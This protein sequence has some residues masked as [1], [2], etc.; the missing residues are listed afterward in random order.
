MFLVGS[1]LLSSTIGVLGD[2]KIKKDRRRMV[3]DA[4]IVVLGTATFNPIAVGVG[5][6][7][8]GTD[9]TKLAIHKRQDRKAQE[10]SVNAQPTQVETLVAVPQRPGYYY[11][12]SNPN[13]LYFDQSQ[14]ADPMPAKLEA[15]AVASPS[16]ITVKIANAAKDGRM[17]TC[18]VE[19]TT[20][21]VPPGYTQTLTAVPNAVISYE[22][23]TGVERYTLMQGGYEFRS[24][25]NTWRFFNQQP[26]PSVASKPTTTNP[27]PE[28]SVPR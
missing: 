12:P 14:A 22:T 28:V 11:F 4:G 18:T 23:G 3:L 19:G 5:L 17:I 6:G 9:T 20:F 15:P 25:D 27:T 8:L 7:M 13:Q 2:D 16:L 24:V 21:S 10:A 26:A 1:I